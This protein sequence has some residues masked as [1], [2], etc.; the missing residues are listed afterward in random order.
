[1]RKF[2]RKRLKKGLSL[3]LTFIMVFNVV[4]SFQMEQA[5]AK[6][7]VNNDKLPDGYVLV[8]KTDKTIAPGISETEIVTNTTKGDKQQIDYMMEVQMSKDSPTKVVASYGSNYDASSWELATMAEQAKGYEDYMKK[9]GIKNETVVAA[10]NA[11]FFHMGTG[12]PQG[13]LVMN[14]KIIKQPIDT[15]FCITKE[16]KA[17]IRDASQPMDDCEQAVGGGPFLVK[18]GEPQMIPDM[19][20]MTRAAIGLKADGSI[21]TFTTHGISDQSSGHTVPEMAS[22]L[23]AAGCVTAINLDGG[24]SA[25]YIYG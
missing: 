3:V 25:T 11:D 15:Y 18:N 1:M 24:G 2:M 5:H 12:E 6:I 22:L 8:K 16:G 10:V 23:A 7:N 14:G 21:V 19:V 4:F 13:A 20:R 17:E 9:N